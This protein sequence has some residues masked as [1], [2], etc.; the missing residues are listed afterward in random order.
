MIIATLI[1]LFRAF[2]H[3]FCRFLPYY[4]H[5]VRALCRL[6]HNQIGS[7]F[8]KVRQYHQMPTSGVPFYLRHSAS[9]KHHK[10]RQ[11]RDSGKCGKEDIAAWYERICAVI[12]ECLISV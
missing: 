6:F 1:F 11:N 5:W 9:Q 4:F 3:F 10:E 2:F 7:I 8:H 12:I